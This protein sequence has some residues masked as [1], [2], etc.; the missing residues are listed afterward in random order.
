[1]KAIIVAVD[2]TWGIGK[3]GSIPWHFKEDFKWF[4]EQ[5]KNSSII[6]GYNTFHELALKFNYYEKK[7][8]LPNRMAYVISSRAIEG[9]ETVKTGFT[10]INDAI[11]HSEKYYP[12]NNI[13]LIGGNKIFEEG[14][15][16]VDTVFLTK[17]SENYDCDVFFP[18]SKFEEIKFINSDMKKVEDIDL[19]SIQTKKLEFWTLKV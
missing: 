5:T 3:N 19:T 18:Q 1:M 12:D 11:S 7:K 4:K 13:F 16:L 9:S 15:P 17:I 14:L 10:S 2:N 6:M 8:L